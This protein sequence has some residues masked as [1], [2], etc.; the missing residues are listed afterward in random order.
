MNPSETNVTQRE[1]KWSSSQ[2][3]GY[4]LSRFGLLAILA[5]LLLAAWFGQVV[6]VI[7]LGLVLSTAGLAKLWSRFSLAG[8]SCQRLLSERRVFPGEDIELR[9]RLVNRKLLPLPWVQLDDEI[10]LKLSPDIL[11][12]SGNTVLLW[13][14]C[15]KT[16]SQDSSPSAPGVVSIL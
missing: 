11:L 1:E 4:L 9:L 14:S 7:L 2:S 3:T 15:R 13:Q 10:P 16:L 8:V 5:G 12:D 6:I